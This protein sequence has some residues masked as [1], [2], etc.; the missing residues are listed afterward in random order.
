MDLSTI[1]RRAGWAAFT[2]M[3]IPFTTLMVS[4]AGM[5]D[6]EY[7][8]GEL[9][10][11]ARYSIVTMSLFFASTFILLFGAPAVSALVN[12]SVLAKGEVAEAKILSISDTGMTIN[13]SPVVRLLLEVQ[14]SNGPSFQAETERLISRLQIPLIQPGAMVKVKYDPDT[15]AVALVAEE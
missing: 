13:N 14:P 10:L 2:L 11:L 9:P 1:M 4:M 3:W 5:P 15:Q 7:A 12:R 6:G 8:W